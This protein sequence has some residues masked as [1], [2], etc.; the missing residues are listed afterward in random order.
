M[1]IYYQDDLVTLYHGDCLGEHR[2]WLEAD[3]L[4]TDPPY[5][6]RWKARPGGYKGGPGQSGAHVRDAVAGDTDTD[7]RDQVLTMWGKRPAIVFGSW[8][9][10]RPEGVRSR[11]IWHKR[12]SSPGPL[13][14]AFMANDEEIYVIGEGWR[15]SSPPLRSVITTTE[16]RSAEVSRIGH[17]TPKPVSLMERL[18]EKCPPGVVAD[19]FVGSGATL[20]AAVNQGRKV[21]GVELEE[22]YCEIIATRLA[23]QTMTLDFSGGAL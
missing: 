10:P 14:A 23:N 1:S 9:A 18:I 15:K 6:I 19:P 22:R 5:G 3:V 7:I 20:V 12:G 16:S 8:R 17:P 13:N 4:V 2:E 21:I 11:L